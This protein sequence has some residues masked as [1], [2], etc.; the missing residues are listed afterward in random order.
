MLR[1][2]VTLLSALSLL[3][4]AAV[5]AFWVDSRVVGTR[6]RLTG[7]PQ[8]AMM[9]TNAPDGMVLVVG[10]VIAGWT[11]PVRMKELDWRPI[12]YYR[13]A[14]APSHYMLAVHHGFAFALTA[15]L[16]ASWGARRLMRKSAPGLC[17]SC[18]YDLRATPGRCPECGTSSGGARVDE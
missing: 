6:C 16:P 12:L 8:D 9:L 5:V 14:D 2:L 7:T 1:R 10:D 11:R 4:C 3:L 18:S 13:S 17:P 15:V